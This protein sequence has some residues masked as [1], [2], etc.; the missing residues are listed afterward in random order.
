MSDLEPLQVDDVVRTSCAEPSAAE[1]STTEG[2]IVR[3]CPSIDCTLILAM[4]YRLLRGRPVNRAK[5]KKGMANWTDA[6]VLCLIELCGEE[7]IQEQLK[8]GK[9]EQTRNQEASKGVAENS[10]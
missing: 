7:A 6:E 1:V 4:W 10:Q 9:K 8:R 5:R 3:R 2:I